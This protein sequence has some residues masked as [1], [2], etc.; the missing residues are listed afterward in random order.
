MSRLQLSGAVICS[1]ALSG[2]EPPLVVGNLD[3]SQEGGASGL[4]E[5]G[6]Y[7]EGPLPAPWQTSFG[8]TFCAYKYRAGFCYADPD[9]EYRVVTSPV[10][11]GPFAA[12]FDFHPR[13]SAG[14]RQARCVREG[15]L[16]SEAYY[17]AWYYVPSNF[18]GASNWNLFH[19]QGGTP[20]TPEP[21]RGSW[22]VSMDDKSGALAVYVLNLLNGERYEADPAA[23]I[24]LDRWFQLEFYLKRSADATGE[25][26][27]FQDGAELLRKTGLTSDDTPFDQWYVGNWASNIAAST[28][29]ITL[30]VDDVTVRL[31]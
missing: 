15:G 31:P 8:D 3:C 6:V 27:L 30:Y 17:G 1:V 28:S 12:A 2:C 11:S 10:R 21:L 29:T 9:S 14:A 26:A 22:D 16:P 19:F 25:V 13:D 23:Q 24:P 18:S 20:G 7:N 5:H 4:N